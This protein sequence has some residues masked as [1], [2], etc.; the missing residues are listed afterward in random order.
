LLE[1]E[2][3]PRAKAEKVFMQ[4]KLP[5]DFSNSERIDNYGRKSFLTQYG[6]KMG[7]DVGG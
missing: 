4:N 6:L 5:P 3:D 1:G 7:R 2:L